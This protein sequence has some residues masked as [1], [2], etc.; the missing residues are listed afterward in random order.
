MDALFKGANE[1]DQLSK[2]I[3]ILGTPPMSWE[4]GYKLAK[5]I[6]VQFGQ[7]TRVPLE[8]IIKSASP[9]AIDLLNQMLQYDPAKRI[10]LTEALHHPFLEP[11]TVMQQEQ[12][13]QQPQ[14]TNGGVM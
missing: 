10:S 1:Q 3:S 4:G 6:G 5:K 8:N 12:Q 2:V 9:D 7:Y 13:A 11:L 14:P